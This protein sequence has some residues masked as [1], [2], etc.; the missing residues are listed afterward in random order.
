[1]P[2]ERMSHVGICVSDLE[3]SIRFYRDL[4][5]FRH[6]SNLQV[7]GEPAARLLR[8]PGADLHAAYLERDGTRIELLWY[9][10]PPRREPQPERRM[11]DLGLTHLSLR[12]SD[13]PDLVEELR[14]QGVRV[15]DDT[16][17]EFPEFGAAAVMITDPDGQW[18][19]LVQA[20]GDP[21]LPP[22]G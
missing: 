22:Q 3:R 15:L 10:A 18:I 11:N 5:G 9:A 14:R 4:L 20:P 12:V 21:S 16:R 19:E 17:L 7:A 6:V 8:L 13:L 1:M 2:I